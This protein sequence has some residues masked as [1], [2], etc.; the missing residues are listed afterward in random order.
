MWSCRTKWQILFCEIFERQ[1]VQKKWR[2]DINS[3]R[4]AFLMLSSVNFPDG[5]QRRQTATDELNM[6]SILEEDDVVCV[7]VRDID[8][9]DDTPHLQARSKK[10]GKL[11]KGQLLKVY[12]YLVKEQR[13]HFHHLEQ[14]GVD[15]IL[16]RNGFIWVGEHVESINKSTTPSFLDE[17]GE[18]YATPLHIRVYIC[19]IANAIRVF[20]ELGFSITVE[21]LLETVVLSESLNVDVADMLGAEFH[22][23]VA[24][25]EA[26]RRKAMMAN[27]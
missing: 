27:R 25:K 2:L 21:A 4:D 22:V 1:V 23:L 19:R 11:E 26:E 12:P 3:A 13:R 24:E 17:D 20:S 14:Y 15:L 9:D 5:I 6:R 8:S 18:K 10:H 7:E 16:G